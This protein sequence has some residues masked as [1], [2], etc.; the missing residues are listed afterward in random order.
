MLQ[1]RL[2]KVMNFGGDLLA[3]H[4][5]TKEVAY[6]KL[7]YTHYNPFTQRWRLVTDPCDYIYSSAKYYMPGEKNYSFLKDLRN[8]F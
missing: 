8:K 1:L 4:L 7:D 6:Q 3:G 5:F 2:I